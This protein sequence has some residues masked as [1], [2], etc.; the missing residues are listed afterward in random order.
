MHLRHLLFTV[1]ET[2]HVAYKKY[3]IKRKFT[4]TVNTK[5]ISSHELKTSELSR[6]LRTP[7]N[8]DVFNTLDKIYLVFTY[9]KVNILYL[10]AKHE[11]FSDTYKVAN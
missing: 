7:E 5:Y 6:V 8:S 9:K 10:F 1:G 3:K 11:P 4:F 2:L